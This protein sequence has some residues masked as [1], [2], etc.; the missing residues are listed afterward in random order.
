MTLTRTAALLV[1][2][3][4]IAGTMLGASPR[5]VDQLRWLSGCW[6][7]RDARS[8]VE[9][10]WTTPNGGILFGIGRTI[11][12]RDAGDTTTSFEI[13]RIYER[14][15]RLVFAAHPFGTATGRVHRGGAERQHGRLRQSDA[16]L[17]AVRP[18]PSPWG[19][20]ATRACRRQDG[21]ERPGLRLSLSEGGLSWMTGE[22]P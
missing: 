18:L 2:V 15:G 19:R 12:R 20:R 5:R 16:R 3:T 22:A 9:E 14:G 6:E 8:A 10:L 13:M 7:Q 17:P 11:V 21:R 1:G 4:V